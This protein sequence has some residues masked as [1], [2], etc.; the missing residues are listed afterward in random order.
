MKYCGN[1]GKPIAENQ[2]FCPYC[3]KEVN[4]NNDTNKTIYNPN[5]L[6]FESK[7]SLIGHY[8]FFVLFLSF[9]L[10]IIPFVI[11][12]IA[13]STYS[14]RI[15]SNK[16]VKE[17]GLISKENKVQLF[18]NVISVSVNQGL[19]GSI[20]NY[21]DVYVNLVGKENLSLTDVKNPNEVAG[22]FQKMI[23][24]NNLEQHLVD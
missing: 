14:V 17:G 21:G 5:K 6:L 23:N 1:C 18:S 19:K 2:K 13:N 9:I 16:I 4:A 15:Y 8:G 10:F 12:V 24:T 20:F 3:G 7:R 22:V 11:I